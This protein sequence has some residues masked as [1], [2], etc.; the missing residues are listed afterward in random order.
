MI[1]TIS[2][3][4]EENTISADYQ[5]DRRYMPK[6]GIVETWEIVW[7]YSTKNWRIALKGDASMNA[8]YSYNASVSSD[9][10]YHPDE[11]RP[12]SQI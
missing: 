2:M 3:P 4:K 7:K 10:P 12:L 6:I 9:I 11:N 5:T 1:F 8:I